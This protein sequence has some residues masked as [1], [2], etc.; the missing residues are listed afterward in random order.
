[1]LFGC[2]ALHTM[3]GR[4]AQHQFMIVSPQGVV[5]GSA[6]GSYALSL[7]GQYPP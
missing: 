5:E 3:P 4:A 6:T 1:M 2:V 7:T